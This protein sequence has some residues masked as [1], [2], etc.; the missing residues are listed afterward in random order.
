[1]TGPHFYDYDLATGDLTPVFITNPDRP[2]AG[3][4]D[5]A[6]LADAVADALQLCAEAFD[7][8]YDNISAIAAACNE[9]IVIAFGELRT[10]VTA[11][12]FLGLFTGP[13]LVPEPEQLLSAEPQPALPPEP[14]PGWLEH[15][16]WTGIQG[17]TGLVSLAVAIAALILA[18]LAYLAM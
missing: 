16:K 10:V 5:N 13:S 17:L 12:F 11:A 15:P 14:K 2:A 1:M 3:T 6:S 18:W 8:I 7:P 4:Y 9:T